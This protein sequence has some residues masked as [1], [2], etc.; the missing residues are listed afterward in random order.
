MQSEIG[1]NTP[2]VMK[3][4]SLNMPKDDWVILGSAP[5]YFYGIIDEIHDLDVLARGKA[6]EIARKSGERKTLPLGDEAAEFFDGK[7][8]VVNSWAPG[9]WDTGRLI[10]RA[11]I[12]EGVKMVSIRDIL[13]WKKMKNREQDKIHVELIKNHLKKN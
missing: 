11:D 3:L 12:V 5:L 8:E 2:I 1:D 6:W 13:R 4:L 7:I 10:G 9:D